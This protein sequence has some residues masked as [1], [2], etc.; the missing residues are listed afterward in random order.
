MRRGWATLKGTLWPQI[1]AVLVLYGAGVATIPGFGTWRSLAAML[2]LA[3]FAGI[4][5]AGQTVVALLGGIDLSIPGV[6]ALAN[7]MTAQLTDDGWPFV[8]TL[9][10][11]LV[12]AVAIGALNGWISKRLEI[13]P[14]IVTLGTGAIIGGAILVW[15]GGQATG[16]APKWLSAFVSPSAKT[17]GLAVPPVVVFWAVFAGVL[18]ILLNRTPFGRRLYAAGANDRAAEIALVPTT[19]IW[20]LAFALS[21]TAAAI[22]GVLLAGFTGQGE[23]RVAEPYLFTTIA[24]VVIGGTS[25]V[26]ARGGYMRTVLGVLALIEITTLLVANNLSAALQQALLGVIVLA[27]VAT[28]GREPPI[29]DRL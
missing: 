15:T 11:I 9:A 7:I 3:A 12:F 2:V 17:F 29:R 25:L 18:L 19:R 5:S 20:T 23:A 14:L 8:A 24:A 10:L 6:M 27:V 26:G 21:A 1:A 4:A 16:F 22:A 13:N 28:Y